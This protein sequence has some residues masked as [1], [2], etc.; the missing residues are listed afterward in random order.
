[1][2]ELRANHMIVR[3]TETVQPGGIFF[4]PDAK[5]EA[6]LIRV[7]AA[8]PTGNEVE[9]EAEAEAEAEKAEPTPV[10]E[11]APAKADKKPTKAGKAQTTPESHNVD[12]LV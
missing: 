3:A 7:N 10:T 1:M 6:W 5:E 4:E 9:A 11:K 2:L 8:T 12:D